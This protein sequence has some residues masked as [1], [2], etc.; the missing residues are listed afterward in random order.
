MIRQLL[1]ICLL[2]LC[3][4][5]GLP[6]HT[7]ASVS[8]IYQPLRTHMH[9]DEAAWRPLFAR[10][11]AQGI[12]TLV[13]QWTQHDDA[14][15]TGDE[16]AWLQRRVADATA[17]DL[18]LILGLS[19]DS[20]TFQRLQ[21]PDAVL[22]A[23]FRK[24]REK[25]RALVRRW[26]ALVPP[27]RLIGW[28]LTLEIDDKRWRTPTA[29]AALTNYL[30][31]TRNDID[32]VQVMPRSLYISSFFTGQMTPPRYAQLL[33]ELHGATGVRLW[34]QDG[35]GTG[36]LNAIE[37]QAYLSAL[38]Q[39]LAPVIQGI[40]YEAFRQVPHHTASE[41]SFRAVPLSATEQTRLLKTRAPCRLDT[42]FFGLNYLGL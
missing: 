28:Y 30:R 35:R 36:L 18:N 4:G 19:A 23:Y 22:P 16:A 15:S 42:G 1:R 33:A 10:L 34:V 38:T 25:D 26:Q 3:L 40:I 21:Q 39:C 2:A 13:F 11:R 17:A 8:V 37:R 24:I 12:D 32:A 27:E 9:I 7:Q 31:H 20:D 41:S 6:S 14:F 5:I 29:Q